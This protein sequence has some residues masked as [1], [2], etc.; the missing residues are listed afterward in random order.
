MPVP[1]WAV[2]PLA[3]ALGPA[4]HDVLLT[5]EEYQAMADGLADS[6]GGA[7]RPTQVVFT[8]WVASNGATHSGAATRAS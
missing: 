8:D 3:G 6:H 4:L 2:P 5:R 7:Y 1:G